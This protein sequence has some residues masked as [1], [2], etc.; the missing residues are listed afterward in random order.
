M[1]CT[2]VCQPR[3]LGLGHAVLCAKPLVGYDP[4]SVLLAD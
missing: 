4:F 3:T 1:V 2:Y